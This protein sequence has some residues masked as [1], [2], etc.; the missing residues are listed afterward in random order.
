MV[1]NTDSK[2]INPV[3]NR[4]SNGVKEILSRGAEEIIEKES[5]EKKLKSG[6]KLTVKFGADPTAPDLH[7]GHSVCL[8][9]LKEFQNL[10]HKIVF[11]IGDFT[12]KIGDPSAR[13]KARPPLSE[14]EIQKNTKTYFEQVGKILNIKKIEIKRNSQW[15]SKINLE[16]FLG[17]AGKFT[18]ARILERDDFKK[19]MEAGREIG[20][21][22]II[23]PILQAYDSWVLRSDVEIGGSDQRFNLLVARDFQQKMGQNPQD[24][25]I[26]PLLLGLEGRQKMSKS[27]GNYIGITEKPE[28]QYGKIMSISDSLLLHYFELCTGLS[29]E[30]L[31]QVKKD[32]KNPKINPRDLKARLAREIATIYWGREEAKRSEREFNRVFKE[33]EIPKDIKIFRL[34]DKNLNILDLLIKLKFA[35][36]R[37]AAR[38]LVEQG[39]VRLI[40]N[41]SSRGGFAF[42][43]KNKKL[44][45][46]IKDWKEE[47][48]IEKGMVAQVGKRKFIRIE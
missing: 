8:R 21:H 14:K 36:S 16:K 24:I 38:T 32:F 27:L 25:I 46:T 42:G 23:Y 4:I 35:P 43:E 26:L 33:K 22:E 28:S 29:S 13:T 45:R 39:A 15:F 12:A 30:E 18:V 3:K 48:K 9:K 2:K 10:G 20:F 31:E 37:S 1:I 6:K 5:L 41:I 44:K 19:R 40:S 17:L 7:L 11:I 47:V 34:E